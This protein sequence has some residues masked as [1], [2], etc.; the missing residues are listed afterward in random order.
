MA[1]VR[2]SARARSEFRAE[3]R[4]LR[5]YRGAEAVARVTQEVAEA[6]NRVAE[7]PLGYAWVGSIHVELAAVPSSFRRVLTRTHG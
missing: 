3:R 5:E 6:V 4:W 2:W 1:T 7:N